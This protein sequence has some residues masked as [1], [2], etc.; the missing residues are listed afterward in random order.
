M[1]ARTRS[2]LRY[3]SFFLFF[4]IAAF[5]YFLLPDRFLHQFGV[6]MAHKES[7]ADIQPDKAYLSR[8]QNKGKRSVHLSGCY[9]FVCSRCSVNKIKAFDMHYLDRPV[10][11]L[12]LFEQDFL[13]ATQV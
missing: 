4:H 1:Q 3:G 6:D 11:I 13:I 2:N 5:L 9:H 8:F 7:H 12:P 10:A